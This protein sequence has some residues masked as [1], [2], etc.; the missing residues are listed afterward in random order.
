MRNLLKLCFL[1]NI[2]LAVASLFILP[3][4]AATHFGFG[5][6]PDNWG[7]PSI[8]AMII[9]VIST[10]LFATTL[11]VPFM[12]K[13]I[14]MQFVNMPNKGY[15]L[16]MENKPKAVKKITSFMMEFGVV[17]LVLILCL[18]LLTIKANLSE[19]VWL[20]EKQFIT[21]LVAYMLYMIYWCVKLCIAFRVPKDNPYKLT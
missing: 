14:P 6:Q 10:L 21:L 13:R 19:P 8:C 20:N 12:I 3:D 1:M 16:T 5:G 9:V 7:P 4:P 17:T 15:W 18:N 2:I 11:F